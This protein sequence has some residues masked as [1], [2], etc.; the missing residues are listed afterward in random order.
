MLSKSWYGVNYWKPK[1]SSEIQETSLFSSTP[2]RGDLRPIFRRGF[3]VTSLRSPP[4]LLGLANGPRPRLALMG[5]HCGRTGSH[6][7]CWKVPLLFLQLCI[8]SSTHSHTRVHSHTHT[9]LKSLGFA[10]GLVSVTWETQIIIWL[11]VYPINSSY[12]VLT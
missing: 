11:I 2:L 3:S 8:H 9:V 7:G 12:T 6:A 10:M 4:W 5:V 1:V